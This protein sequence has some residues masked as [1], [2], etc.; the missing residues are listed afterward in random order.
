MVLILRGKRLGFSLRDVTQFLN[1]YDTD[2]TGTEQL[3]ALNEA[4][5]L[6]GSPPSRSSAPP[7]PRPLPNCMSIARQSKQ[8]AR[9]TSP[10]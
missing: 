3:R 4:V 8:T 6:T 5:S 1:L 7:S 9:R 2:H 10:T